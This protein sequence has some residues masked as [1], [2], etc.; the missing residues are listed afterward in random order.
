M[1]DDNKAAVETTGA[2]VERGE[3]DIGSAVGVVVDTNGAVVG[4]IGHT[5]SSELVCGPKDQNKTGI[6]FSQ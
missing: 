6:T 3:V 5:R 2:E 4:F 1:I